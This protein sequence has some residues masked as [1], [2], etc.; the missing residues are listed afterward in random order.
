MI[1]NIAERTANQLNYIKIST[2]NENNNVFTNSV[3]NLLY[4][5]KRACG[6]N[7]YTYVYSLL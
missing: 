5:N 7:Y 3:L 6:M 1:Y 4:T 2:A